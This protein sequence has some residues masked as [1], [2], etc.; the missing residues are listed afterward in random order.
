MANYKITVLEISTKTVGGEFYFGGFVPASETFPNPFSFTLLQGAGKT[1]LI[2]CGIDLRDPTK[3]AIF[4]ACGAQ[5]GHGPVEV[6]ATVGVK[7]EEVDAVILTH[8]HFDHASGIDCFP[9]A[10]FYLQRKELEGW[11]DIRNHPK[12]AALPFFCM[13]MSDVERLEKLE[14][15]GRLTL[16]D[17]DV[18]N[19]FPGISVYSV[20]FGHSFDLQMVM[21]DTEKGKFLHTGDACNRPENLLGTESFPFYLPNTEFAVGPALNIV[22]GFDRIMELVHGDVTHLIMTHD[23]TRRD[24]FPWHKSELGLS[25]FEIC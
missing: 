23:D 2:D 24:L 25:I 22:R 20:G 16:L 1:I 7:P 3:A 11:Q 15:T 19:L 9:N 13:D 8:A 14:K 21:V 4:G 18:E 6:L 10:Q 5:N 17:G 12:Y